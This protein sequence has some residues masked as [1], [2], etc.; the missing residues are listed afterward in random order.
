MT[1]G[2][3]A[4]VAAGAL[5]AFV[6]AAGVALLAVGFGDSVAQPAPA[7]R[8]RKATNPMIE[9]GDLCILP[10]PAGLE[11]QGR[12][13]ISLM[14]LCTPLTVFA[15]VSARFFRSSVGTRPLKIAVPPVTFTSIA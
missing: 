14:M 5:A 8:T 3:A 10:A 15:S 9:R 13:A 2:T 7:R 11:V 6:F 4:A 1:A 12:T